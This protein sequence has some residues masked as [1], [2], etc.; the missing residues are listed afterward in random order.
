MYIR[1]EIEDRTKI[2]VHDIAPAIRDLGD[3]SGRQLYALVHKTDTLD[4]PCTVSVFMDR[5][6]MAALYDQ[7]KEIL[8]PEEHPATIT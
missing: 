4:N 2:Y 6:Q 8:E 1:V 7:L 3:A 5:Q